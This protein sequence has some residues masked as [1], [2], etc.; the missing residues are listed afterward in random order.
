MI[1]HG[2][3]KFKKSFSLL[4]NLSIY[5]SIMMKQFFKRVFR[6]AGTKKSRKLGKKGS[7]FGRE[8]TSF[9]I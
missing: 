3:K 8:W 4:I 1:Y 5:L 2:F 7:H 9:F 6:A